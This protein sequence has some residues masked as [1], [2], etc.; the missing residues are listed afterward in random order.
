MKTHETDL[1][2]PSFW[3]LVFLHSKVNGAAMTA[4]SYRAGT[5]IGPR[6]L[7]SDGDYVVRSG[8]KLRTKVSGTRRW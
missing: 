7:I 3:Q 2:K 4:N 1:E 6:I 5:G 8:T